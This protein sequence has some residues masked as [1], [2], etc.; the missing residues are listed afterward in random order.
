MSPYDP[1]AFPPFAVTVDLVVL[2]V[3]RHA[4]CA[5]AVRRGEAPFQGRWAL[6]GGFVKTDED[7]GAAAARELAEE[8][9]LSALGPSTPA[10]VPGSGAHLEQL[11][12][13][14]DPDR[15]PRMRVVSVAHLALAPDLPAP[16]AGGDAHSARWAPVEV[17]LGQESGIVGAGEPPAPLAFDHARILAD[18]VERARSKIEYS[19]LATAF[20]PQEFTVGELRRVYEAVWGVVLDP[21]NFH[22]KVTGTPGFLVP[23]GGTTT[24]Q[25]G[26][27][28]QLFRA[29]AAT[30]LNPPMLRP[31]V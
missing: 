30:L 26:R 16:R 8:T 14:G 11:G 6:P 10:P 23:S 15:D 24:R 22:R 9:G 13:Y 29:G 20:C 4:L 3:R 1:S 2:T 7:L 17:L 31:E 5:L 28:A 12:T 19:S 27:P 25:G 21:R 18:G